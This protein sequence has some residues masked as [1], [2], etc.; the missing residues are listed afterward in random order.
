MAAGLPVVAAIATGSQSLVDDG[1]TGRLVR[2]GAIDGFAA[3]LET[4]CR[5]PKRR[6]AAGRAG[7]EASRRYG[8]DEVNQALVDGYWRVIRQRHGGGRPSVASP[9]R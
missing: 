8:W 4:Y 6:Q 7:C 9:V 1:V 3:A 2:A 5:D